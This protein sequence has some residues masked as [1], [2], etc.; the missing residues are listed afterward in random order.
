MCL[1]IT[2]LVSRLAKFLQNLSLAYL[3][4]I[5]R[6]LTYLYNIRFLAL[7]YS[8]II[9]YEINQVLKAVFN[10]SFTDNTLTH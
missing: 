3:I 5:N 10:A 6:L 9:L 8:I 2:F 7:K 4:K 1:D